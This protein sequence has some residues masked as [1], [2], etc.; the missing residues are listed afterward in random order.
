V[1]VSPIPHA[2]ILEHVRPLLRKRGIELEV[3][4]FSDY[5][6]PNLALVSGELDANYFQHVPFMSRFNRDHN[7]NLVSVTAVHLEPLGLYPG[8]VKSL[9]GLRDGA[10]IAIPNDPVN[11]GRSLLLL[12]SAG[13]LQLRTGTATGATI[14]DISTNPRH[15]QIKELEAAQL[16]RSLV[17]CDA[18]VINTNYA[19][20][21]KL[22]PLRDAIYLENS[23]SPYANIVA[24]T[25]ERA[26]DF[27]LQA[28]AKALNSAES[29]RFIL[30][31]YKG[32]VMPAF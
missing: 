25:P 1:G 12:Q 17:D 15:L 21:A 30:D 4:N 5:V 24:A 31:K 23:A 16:P 13:L 18:A 28:L 7:A 22:D 27:R 6:Q 20:A 11:S 3:V 10:L 9:G 32:A 14:A 2:E 26:R 29:R 19:L 8:R